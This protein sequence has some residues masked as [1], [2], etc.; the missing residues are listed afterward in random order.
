ML[1]MAPVQQ[2][3]FEYFAVGP[4]HHTTRKTKLDLVHDSWQPESDASALKYIVVYVHQCGSGLHIL[5]LGY[6][7]YD[8]FNSSFLPIYVDLPGGVIT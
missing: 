2:Q 5:M 3:F 8:N 4:Q 6:Q 1:H 7:W